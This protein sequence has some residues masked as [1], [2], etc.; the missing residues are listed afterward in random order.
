MR[1]AMEMILAARALEEVTADLVK[2]REKRTLRY[3]VGDTDITVRTD[4]AAQKLADTPRLTGD[5]E[6]D[7]IELAATSLDRPLI[8]SRE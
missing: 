6:W 2:E 7:A 4:E 5:P 1:E 8:K 3:K